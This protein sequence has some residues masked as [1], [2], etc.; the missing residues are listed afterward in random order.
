MHL[1]R[2]ELLLNSEIN[3]TMCP[4]FKWMTNIIKFTLCHVAKGCVVLGRSY[5]KYIYGKSPEN[6]IPNFGIF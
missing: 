4:D 3:T 5:D 2:F 6:K 1:E